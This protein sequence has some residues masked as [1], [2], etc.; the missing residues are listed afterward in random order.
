MHHACYL[1]RLVRC[2]KT[3]MPKQTKRKRS[4]RPAWRVLKIRRERRKGSR[5]ILPTAC[6]RWKRF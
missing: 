5:W 1:A 3:R 6:W 2:G 4:G